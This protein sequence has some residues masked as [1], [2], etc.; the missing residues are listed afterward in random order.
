MTGTLWKAFCVTLLIGFISGSCQAELPDAP[1]KQASANKAAK[2]ADL[3]FEDQFGREA[4]LAS[5]RGNVAVLVY[6]DRNGTDVCREY[7]EHLH[8]MFHPSAKGQPPE[9]ARQAPVVDLPG[10]PNGQPSPDVV[11][12]PVACAG[13]VPRVVKDFIQGQVK[14][15]SPNVTVWMDFANV[16]SENF[17]MRS[18]DVNL[19]VFDAEGR[20]RMKVNGMPDQETGKKLLQT[21]QNLRAEAAGLR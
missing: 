7:G 13:K 4:E 9:K 2:P 15:N 5:L 14:K 11:V 20:A 3:N 19:V 8:V 18:G 1:V 10:M 17:G 21:I 12:V 16:M 6:G